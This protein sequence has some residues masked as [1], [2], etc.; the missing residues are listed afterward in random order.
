MFWNIY[1]CVLKKAPNDWM[2]HK[3]NKR[4]FTL[5][6]TLYLINRIVFCVL[7]IYLNVLWNLT[8]P[9]C[10]VNN[11]LSASFFENKI[12][13]KDDEEE[14]T[15]LQSKPILTLNRKPKRDYKTWKNESACWCPQ[16]VNNPCLVH[17]IKCSN[18]MIFKTVYSTK[19][20]L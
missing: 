17:T 14:K 20:S 15:K 6:Y 1:C 3:E 12:Q 4:G 9:L 2:C 18:R 5:V 8:S 7:I 19:W 10:K 16:M 11:F 13:S